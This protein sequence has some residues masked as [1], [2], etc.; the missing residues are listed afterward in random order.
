M[1]ILLSGGNV[2]ENGS[3][4]KKDVAVTDGVISEIASDI[5]VSDVDIVFDVNDKNIVPGFVDVHVHLREPG[6][7]YKETIKTGTKAAAK[8]GYTAVCS[9][10]NLDPAPDSVE[11]ILIQK[12]KIDESACISVFPYASITVG[13]KGR[14]ELTDFDSLSEYAIGFSDD[15]T[16]VQTKELM[17]EAMKKAKSLGKIIAAH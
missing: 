15:G 10:P 16:G 14:G 4:S 5:S 2:F 12:K 3:F 13:R 8:G 7:S 6:F 9:M 17:E 11:N 1:K